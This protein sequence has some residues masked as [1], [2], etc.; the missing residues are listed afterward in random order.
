M[1]IRAKIGFE[2]FRKKQTILELMLNRIMESYGELLKLGELP[3]A[4]GTFLE[5]FLN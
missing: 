2:A 5:R 3:M 1:R 4:S